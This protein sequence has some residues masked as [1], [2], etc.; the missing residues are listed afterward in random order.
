MG[1]RRRKMARNLA[2][3]ILLSLA[4]LGFAVL[5]SPSAPEYEESLVPETSLLADVPTKDLAAEL[6]QRGGA[7]STSAEE[8]KLAQA[9]ANKGP[10]CKRSGADCS[11]DHECCGH[12][13]RSINGNTWM[14]KDCSMRRAPG[15]GLFGFITSAASEVKMRCN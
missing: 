9:L 13:Q 12:Q 4:V 8:T 14:H 2:Y 6:L 3:A 11:E 15:F 7:A 5:G 10:T 1:P